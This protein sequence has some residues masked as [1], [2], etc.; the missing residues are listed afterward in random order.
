MEIDTGNT[1]WLLV[2]TALVLLMTP[3]LALFYG[4]LN[5][6]K[7]ALNMMMMSFSSIGLVSILWLFYGFT[8]AF[9]EGGK[10]IG[11]LGQYLGTK[12]FVGESD[13]WGETGIPLYVFIA[14]QM[15]F[16]VITVALISGA[17]SDRTKFAGW[18][19]FAFGWATLVYF[20]VAH[21]VWGG[22]LIGGDIGALDFAGGTA[23]HINAGAAA[24]AL[25]LV[26]GK[27]VGW[28]R[29][30]AKPHNIP[31]VALGAGLLWFGWFG[32]NAGSEL[33]AD[34][35]TALAF[36]NTQVATAGAL[37]GWIVVE[38]LRDGRPT[39]VGASSGAVAGLV[40]I[41]PACAFITPA[42]AVLL[43]LVAGAV[44]ALAVGLKYRL[45]YDDSLDVVGVHFVGGWIGC[46]WI[47]LFGTA[48][49][50]SLVASD[51][52]LVGGDATLLGKQALGALIVTVYSFAI[53][54]ALG[55]VIDKTIGFRIASEAEIEGI[56]VAEHAESAYDLSPTTG[57]SAGGAFAMAGLG[58][59]KP[60]APASTEADEPAEPV[61]EKVAG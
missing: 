50:S 18:L 43:G 51:G 3:G 16:A 36:V 15:M 27:R 26:L 33:T 1:A 40:A 9:G 58:G 7:G 37:L 53:A 59:T 41:T 46:L 55:F 49:V 5:R 45:G 21:M 2:S 23:V 42:A 28:P 6:S 38:W 52:L 61:S 39:L 10:F 44:C 11:D 14:F 4:G 31:L 48:S 56:D 19:L 25:V 13:L 22:G 54:Y 8:V 57:S 17:L 34:G 29:E 12:T 60:A 32:F 24:L 35:V 30:S 20:P 47:G